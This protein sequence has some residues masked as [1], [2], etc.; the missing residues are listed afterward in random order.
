MKTQETAVT[1]E[2]NAPRKEQD[3]YCDFCKD[4]I[5]DEIQKDYEH[6]KT[7]RDEL[8]AALKLV[9]NDKNARFGMDKETNTPI[10][11][12]ISRAIRNA[13]MGQQ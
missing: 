2:S 3:T 10:S 11:Q 4:A 5:A 12:I 9:W 8:L 1:G 13:E 6:V 7:Q